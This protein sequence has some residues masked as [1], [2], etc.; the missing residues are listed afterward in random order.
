[1][2]RYDLSLKC[3]R[4]GR[5]MLPWLLSGAAVAAPGTELIDRASITAIAVEIADQNLGQF[6]VK[7]SANEIAE[8]VGKN[9]AEWQYP[10]KSSG[11]DS[12]HKLL[13]SLGK[14]STGDTPVGFSWTSGDSDPRGLGFQKARI[15]PI[16][17][18]LKK[19]GSDAASIENKATVSAHQLVDESSQ[20]KVTE[21][22]VDHVST[23][24]FD[25]LD[26]LK[27][28]ATGNRLDTHTFKPS[29]MPDVQVEVKEVPA[30]GNP[31][32]PSSTRIEKTTGEAAGETRKQIIIHN[33]GSPVI[34][35]F[36]YERR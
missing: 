19:I 33:Q 32:N 11:I 4:I 10:V 15:L 35:E 12:S 5:W 20:A 34:L 7:L 22:L 36:G 2:S 23:V 17:C 29:W 26:E 28:P 6:G 14:V 21:K 24:C 16:S 9:L 13:I 30:L 3:V 8:R 27:L 1:M 25:L 31:E 18:H